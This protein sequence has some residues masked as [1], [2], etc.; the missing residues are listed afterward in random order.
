M[1][2]R[3]FVWFNRNNFYHIQVL[4]V[5]KSSDFSLS[6]YIYTYIHY[7]HI[8]ALKVRNANSIND[9]ISH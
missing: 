2:I 4:L 6:A 7:V 9:K 8:Y 3:N 5:K 1:I